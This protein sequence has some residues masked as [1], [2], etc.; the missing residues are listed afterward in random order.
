M[1]LCDELVQGFAGRQ[2]AY[3][4]AGGHWACQLCALAW[5]TLPAA[6]CSSYS[7][8]DITLK[9]QGKEDGLPCAYESCFLFTGR[10][11]CF[12]TDPEHCVLSSL[13]DSDDLFGAL[14]QTELQASFSHN[15]RW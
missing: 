5:A 2:E 4:T 13:M 6:S 7:F 1:T 11:A 3:G 10:Q 15:F 12:C 9:N 8:Q 14:S